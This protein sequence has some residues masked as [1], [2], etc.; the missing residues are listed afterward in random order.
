VESGCLWRTTDILQI[1]SLW[2]SIPSWHQ[3]RLLLIS[4]HCFKANDPKSHCKYHISYKS[5]Y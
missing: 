2:F 3:V 1:H 5:Y 4:I